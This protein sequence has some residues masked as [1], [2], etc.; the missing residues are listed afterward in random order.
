MAML[1]NLRNLIFAGVHPRY[2]KWVMNKLTDEKSIESSRQF[3]TRF[4]S[5]YEVIPKDLDDFN[6]QLE[7][8]NAPPKEGAVRRRPK[9]KL[10]PAFMPNANLFQDYRKALDTAVKL[11]T[12]HNIKPI[13]GGTVVFCNASAEMTNACNTAKNMGAINRLNEVGTLLGLMCK[14]ACEDCDFRVFGGPSDNYPEGHA[15][16]KLIEGSIL[17][18]M[19]VVLDLATELG[20]SIKFPF[21]YIENLILEK[22]RIDNL[23]ILS[24]EQTA[25]GDESLKITQ[26]L[27]KYR[28]EVNPDLLFVS[29]DLSGRGVSVKSGVDRHPNDVL[30]SGFSDSILRFIAERGDNNQ[31]QYVENIDVAKKVTT[32]KEAANKL[33]SHLEHLDQQEDEVVDFA[34]PPPA[35]WRTAR[36]FISSTFLDMHAERDVLTRY[37]FPELRERCKTINVHLFEVD[38]RWGVTEEE[39]KL[40]RN[41]QIC[42]DEI[43][44][45]RPFFVG[46]MGNRYGWVPDEYLV[47]D[48]PRFDWL[49]DYPAGRSITE[50]EF[51]Y[52][53][54]KEKSHG[55]FY[56]RDPSFLEKVPSEYLSHFTSDEATLKKIDELKRSV[57]RAGNRPVEYRCSWAGVVD[58]KPLVKG[59]ESFRKRVVEDLWQSI[60]AEFGDS[61][62]EFDISPVDLERAH[63]H[64]SAEIKAS[65]FIGRVELLEQI[66]KAVD[67]DKNNTVVIVGKPGS[68][69]SA[70]VSKFVQDYA[71][72]HPKVF[73]LP[74]FIGATPGS[75]DIRQTLLR[76]CNEL[77]HFFGLD[78]EVPEDYP[79]LV[80]AFPQIVEQAAFRAR[81]LIVIDGLDQ[82]SKA[83][84]AHSLDW[85]PASLPVKVVISTLYG[86]CY[87]SLRRRNHPE[88][89]VG[90]LSSKER[91]EIVKE[92][93]ASFRKKLDDKPMN[94][95]MRVLL[96]KT[97]ADKPLYLM[98][99]CQELRVFG[100]F[101]QLTEKIKN[102]AQTIPRLLEETLARLEHDHGK[103][104]MKRLMSLLICAR[105]GLLEEEL[106][107]LLSRTAK[108]ETK[109]PVAVWS[110]LLNSIQWLLKPTGLSN[111]NVIE[112]F[113]R[114]MP[115]A[116]RKRYFE[117]DLEHEL[118]THKSIAEYF[119]QHATIRDESGNI[120][121]SG[122]S[123]RAISEL[124]YHLIKARQWKVLQTV[125]CSI[126][127]IEMKC[128]LGMSYELVGDYVE[129]SED[130]ALW[131]N[132]DKE[133]ALMEEFRTFITSNA[134]ILSESPHLT[135]Q[136]ALNQPDS[137]APAQVAMKGADTRDYL[138]WL[139][140]PN[141]HDPCRMTLKFSEA[142]TSC[143]V[144]HDNTRIICALKD[145]SIK[146]FDF[147]SGLEVGSCIGHSNWITS[148]CFSPDGSQI[149]S[150]SWDQTA[151]L[152]DASNGVEIAT[153]NGHRR[154]LN[155]CKFS[156]DG[157]TILTASWDCTLRI[158]DAL[159]TRNYKV[160]RGHANPVNYC[161]FSV[162]STRIASASWDGNIIIWDVQS[163]S[164]LKTLSG[165]TKS[166]RS[167]Q[168]SPNGKQIASTSVDN[169]V[170]IWDAHAGKC[171]TYLSGHVKPINK[172]SYSTDGQQ[173][174]SASD[175][176]TLIVWDAV[177]GKQINGTVCPSGWMNDAAYSPDGR[178]IVTAGSECFLSIWDANDFTELGRMIGHSRTVNCCKFSPDGTRVLSGSDD[179]FLRIWDVKTKET[180]LTLEGHRDAINSCCYSPDGS[181]VVS[182]S[183]DFTAR[184]WD[185]RTGVE[186][187]QLSGHTNVVRSVAYSPNGKFVASAGRDS[188]VF[189][190]N[191]NTGKSLAKFAGHKDWINNVNFSPDSKKLVSCSWDFNLKIWDVQKGKE[192][193][194]LI[195]HGSSVST[196]CFSR[197]GKR[198]ISSSFDGTLKVW[199]AQAGTEITTLIGHETR[200]NGIDVG[201]NDNVV[202]V[203][204]DKTIKVWDALAGIELTRHTGHANVIN[205]CTF[206][207]NS[208][209]LI[210]ASEDRTLKLWD[211]CVEKEHIGHSKPINAVAFSPNGGLLASASD[212]TTI[213]LWNPHTMKLVRTL[214]GH[215]LSVR[216]VAFSGDGSMLVSGGD[217]LT[218]N[219]WDVQTGRVKCS[220]KGHDKSVRTCAFSPDGK[221]IATGSWDRNVKVWD[222]DRGGAKVAIRAKLLENP[223]A[224]DHTHED[225]VTSLAFSP[226]G[227]WL[228][229][230]SREGYVSIQVFEV[231]TSKWKMNPVHER[232]ITSLAWLPD[233]TGFL[234]GDYDGEVTEWLVNEKR[235]FRRSAVHEKRVNGLAV[236][237]NGK[238]GISASDDGKLF[239][240][241]RSSRN[242]IAEFH[243]TSPCTSVAISAKHICVSD[244][245]GQL[246][247][248]SLHSTP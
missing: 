164:L 132:Q 80:Q 100:V 195:G 156:P 51:Y 167:C 175:D 221:I 135:Y 68:G 66:T 43:D 33:P 161:T 152:W 239:V 214:H 209:Q 76:L 85:L 188:S 197:D 232:Y 174:V 171:I 193:F 19:K 198:V 48:E 99:A 241:E 191:A 180:V 87:E 81:I 28:Q 7:T 205:D 56:F 121:W 57:K 162:D 222:V 106:L 147:S 32:A 102:M 54:I 211:S 115:K 166:V 223:D 116:I 119:Y 215:E 52:A 71:K 24:H 204:D 247:V 26:I 207:P 29:V 243:C 224:S 196:C 208:G 3:P 6:T 129:A 74:H 202:S 39:T 84:R 230:A 93:L 210:S 235:E 168:F 123:A 61:P 120:T 14:Y 50:L 237:P 4:F 53:C 9:K 142:I 170:R 238:L 163:G 83:N 92:T 46:L 190:W 60:V 189:L 44:R 16:A 109:L 176:M 225:W 216:C 1:R 111:E 173:L 148:C 136:Q 70:L 186:I 12:I 144:N 82:L 55:H 45:C 143:A 25:A 150:S 118:K 30:I 47:P 231:S 219:L 35:K 10:T 228:L 114:E 200:V 18:N 172:C 160:L 112:L 41:I 141:F 107:V 122:E 97:D 217:D 104:M 240:W 67:S 149:L 21:D 42:L 65:N 40:N 58:H 151:K 242:P 244:A 117:H 72:E 245:I 178:L 124:P 177:L 15:E 236:S 194:T 213:K 95:Q 103:E 101:E 79:E 62:T 206:V 229:T 94:D 185:A 90:P 22:K 11:A 36:V 34:P 8:H 37:V 157:K 130:S 126:S 182:A 159:N 64:T 105:N 63:H 49:K 27:T 13:R 134:H 187:F 201:P 133:K 31:L 137:S 153:L 108:G 20:P 113:H 131:K 192:K 38:L 199:D 78:A 69:K 203:S 246:F 75:T 154:L 145:C 226:N 155:C 77:V 128:N 2:H 125:L 96:K 179:H 212:D 220:F 234:Y 146:I 91:K 183:D 181:R 140:K 139:N 86:H 5:A 59:L 88:I 110:R 165:H 127:F 23:I 158:W 184:I 248:L 218:C 98:I 89:V 233:S 169:T 138:K 227:Q 17:E 73:V